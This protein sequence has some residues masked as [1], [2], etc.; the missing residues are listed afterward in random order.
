MVLLSPE[1]IAAVEANVPLPAVTAYVTCD[2]SGHG[3]ALQLTRLKSP[4]ARHVLM[5]APLAV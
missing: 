1:F 4:L 5:P 3:L 2:P